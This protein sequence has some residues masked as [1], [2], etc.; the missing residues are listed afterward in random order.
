MRC[1]PTGRHKMAKRRRG[2][3]AT[4]LSDTQRAV[5]AELVPDA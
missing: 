4:D 2:A 3:Y 5:I 1:R